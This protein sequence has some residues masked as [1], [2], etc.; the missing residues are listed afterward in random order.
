MKPVD[1]SSVF[2]SCALL[3]SIFYIP[4]AHA[5]R[6]ALSA[7]QDSK[8]LCELWAK[9]IS[10]PTEPVSI[11]T[12]SLLECFDSVLEPEQMTRLRRLWAGRSYISNQELAELGISSQMFPE[13]YEIRLSVPVDW[14]RTSPVSLRDPAPPT[15]SH[16]IPPAKV[17]AYLNYASNVSYR[18][19]TSGGSSS[20]D[21]SLNPVF[22]A[23]DLVF[24]SFHRFR[25][26]DGRFNR[27]ETHVTK[28]FKDSM[29]RL[30]AGDI[31]APSFSLFGNFSHLGVGLQKNFGISPQYVNRPLGERDIFLERPARVEIFVNGILLRVLSLEAGRH[32]IRDI[33]TN[34]GINTVVLRITESGGDVRVIQFQSPVEESLLKPGTQDF[35]Y[36]LGVLSWEDSEGLHYSKDWV[37]SASYRRGLSSVWTAGL[38]AQSSQDAW[39]SG[40]ESTAATNIGIFRL[41]S[42]L[43]GE[44]QNF[45][46]ALRASYVW[47]CPCAWGG[48]D[49][50]FSLGAEWFSEN[51]VRK[52]FP[53]TLAKTGVEHSVFS[54]FS[55]TLSST[56][57]GQIS[58]ST[59]DVQAVLELNKKFGRSTLSGLRYSQRRELNTDRV[60]H[61][62]GLQLTYQFDD[63]L[64]SVN[65]FASI[66]SRSHKQ[67]RV[68]AVYNNPTTQNSAQASLQHAGPSNTA[69]LQ[70]A[71]GWQYADLAAGID[72]GREN[73]ENSYAR[74]R[75]SPAGSIAWADGSWGF[76]RRIRDSLVLID[77]QRDHSVLVNGDENSAEARIPPGRSAVI[78][79]T[80]AYRDK[81]FS[82]TRP[83]AE[84]ARASDIFN[85]RFVIQPEYK[86]ATVYR[87]EGADTL[88]LQGLMLDE[89]GKPISLAGGEF[90]ELGS[91]RRVLFFT[92]DSGEFFAE[93]LRR[94]KYQVR[95]FNRPFDTTEVDLSD[96][97]DAFW[98]VGTLRAHDK[99]SRSRQES[100]KD[101]P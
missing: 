8:Y 58:A 19:S 67:A 57:S 46:S 7:S 62:V 11:E 60:D 66:P 70:G 18:Q 44:S 90:V 41:E 61:E 31:D 74:F 4:H 91:G 45:G 94:K 97:K 36:N 82:L 78:T 47:I 79:T 23:A 80:Q 38:H 35:S 10:Q 77:N 75:F 73:S 101:R 50:R 42:A 15:S 98:N 5:Q 30:R 65:S 2:V 25:S 28:D 64:R 55:S 27:L 37:A 54:S 20:L 32:E 86:T 92:D 16:S 12:S 39:V 99:I 24:E 1:I 93:D 95:F 53:V 59:Q 85:P 68:D 26:E 48:Y 6:V 56:I 63:G 43:S 88:A 34:R 72:M 84:D 87:L 33:P 69:S 100:P 81:N 13:T 21:G 3:G 51:Y 52:L 96:V 22:S 49:Q 17:S 71:R 83:L 29:I 40:L 76:G 89:N 9:D 14:R